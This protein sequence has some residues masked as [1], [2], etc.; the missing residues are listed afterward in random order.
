MFLFMRKILHLIVTM[1]PTHI[2]SYIFLIVSQL[3]IL[4]NFLIMDVHMY[5]PL[6]LLLV[7]EQP[8]QQNYCHLFLITLSVMWDMQYFHPHNLSILL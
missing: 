5:Y 8:H 4:K 2:L 7:K 6:F 1:D 3:H